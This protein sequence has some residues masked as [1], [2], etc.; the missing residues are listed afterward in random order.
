[1]A[2]VVGDNV[3]GIQGVFVTCTNPPGAP[4]ARHVAIAPP[5]PAGLLRSDAVDGDADHRARPAQIDFMVQAVSGVGKVTLDNNVGAFY[6]TARSRAR[7]TRRRSADADGAH[8]HLR[9]AG[10]ASGTGRQ[11][12][13]TVRLTGGAGAQLTGKV[14]EVG[15]AEVPGTIPTSGDP[16]RVRRLSPSARP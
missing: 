14:V 10:R 1:M 3:A 4:A 15:S 11:F 7:S 8:L 6:R 16:A 12:H 2:N 13:V 5:A 9:P